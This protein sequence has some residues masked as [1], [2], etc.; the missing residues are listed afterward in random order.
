MSQ[1]T[2]EATAAAIGDEVDQAL[3]GGSPSLPALI[4]AFAILG[5][6]AWIAWVVYHSGR[7]SF[8]VPSSSYVPFA[9]LFVLAFA[10]ERLLEPFTGMIGNPDAVKAQTAAAKTLAVRSGT[11]EATDA[12]KATAKSAANNRASR[13]VVLWAVA[14]VVAMVVSAALGFF[15]LRSV[16]STATSPNRFLDLIITGLVVGA[17]TKPLHDLVSRVQAPS[18]SSGSSTA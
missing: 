16:D 9:G 13:A 2:S 5:V 8:F 4:S 15:L 6:G 1:V 12:A 7:P 17:G 10:I 18:K 11:P 3:L 14:S